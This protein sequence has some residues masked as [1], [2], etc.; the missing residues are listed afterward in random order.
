MS[1]P[2]DR[3]P[4]DDR[5]DDGSGWQEPAHLGGEQGGDHGTDQGAPREDPPAGST[6]WQPPG[7]DLPPADP[8]RTDRPAPDR[9]AGPG[10]ERPPPA[11]GGLFGGRRRVRDPGRGREGLR[12]TE[13][14]LVG[15]QGWAVQHGWTISDGDRAGATPPLAELVATAPCAA[16]Q[17]LP[18]GRGAA[19][20]GRRARAGGLR[21][22]LRLR[23]VR[24]P[25]VRG[26]RGAVAGRGARVPALPG[27]LLE[28][29]HR[30]SR[31]RCP[32]ATRP[33]DAALG[34]AGGRGLAAAA[35]PRAGPRGAGAAAG[36]RRRRR[37]LVRR[38]ATWPRSG[39][40]GTGRS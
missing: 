14:D 22:R 25:A 26:H 19:R 12:A 20:P 13:G 40:T 38:P 10:T 31:C 4:F 15:A 29:P 24:R 35:A 17:G 1:S 9:P 16:G 37:V 34:A 32:A 36:H 30:R 2:R 6:P 39:P 5:P 28:A 18:P 3:D 27:P 21:R 23:P 8:S 7:W 33:F 11:G